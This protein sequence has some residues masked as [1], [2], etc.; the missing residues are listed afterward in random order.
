ML[1]IIIYVLGE[2]ICSELFP[3][4]LPVKHVQARGLHVLRCHAHLI[5]VKTCFVVVINS[6]NELIH[7]HKV[8]TESFHY[9]D[10]YDVNDSCFLNKSTTIQHI[11]SEVYTTVNLQLFTFC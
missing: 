11:D 1:I 8:Y 6:L 4:I 9:D 2:L 10:N 3:F 5:N 7:F